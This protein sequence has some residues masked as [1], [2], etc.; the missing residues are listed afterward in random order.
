MQTPI[1][2]ANALRQTPG[3]PERCGMI[4]FQDM[5]RQRVIGVLGACAIV[6]LFIL[7]IRPYK[8]WSICDQCGMH[9]EVKK[10]Q[11][12]STEATLYSRS[13]ES[14][15]SLSLVMRNCGLI[16]PHTH[17]WVFGGANGNGLVCAIG[18]GTVLLSTT[19]GPGYADL[20][21]LLHDR[22]QFAFRDRVVRGGLDLKTAIVFHGL[23][24]N[25]PKAT[26]SEAGMKKWVARQSERLDREIA[27]LEKRRAAA[28]PL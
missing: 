19:Q 1:V 3:G 23:G 9:R 11:I 12:V 8:A 14:D 22:G 27:D 10:W 20:V 24:Y 21:Q 18:S 28:N 26:I 15:T 4:G 25:L 17:N 7:M 5:S 16:S 2:G 13:E 6:I